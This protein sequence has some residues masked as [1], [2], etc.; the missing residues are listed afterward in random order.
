MNFNNSN[1]RELYPMNGKKLCYIINNELFH[2]KSGLTRRNG[3]NIDFKNIKITFEKLNFEIQWNDNCRSLEMIQNLQK[4]SLKSDLKDYSI[5]VCVILSHGDEGIIYGF[6]DSVEINKLLAIFTEENCE[7]LRDKPKIFLIQACKGDKCDSG[8]YADSIQ[9]NNINKM[10]IEPNFFIGY[11][12]VPGY[13]SWRNQVV[14]SWFISSLCDVIN[15]NENR[16]D[17]VQL[18][19]RVNNRVS[20]YRSNVNR[21]DMNNKLQISSF[22]CM[23]LKDVYL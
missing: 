22:V 8:A 16:E 5:F 14:G 23:L 9:S 2:K 15:S 1:S 19:V 21:N 11:S 10:F 18:L 13:F 7:A 17:L 4:I 20:K 6:E 3:T 12:T